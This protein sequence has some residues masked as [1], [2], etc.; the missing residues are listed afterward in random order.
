MSGQRSD[1]LARLRELAEE[2]RKPWHP[3][4]D[5]SLPER[6]TSEQWA[7]DVEGYLGGEWGEFCRE[8]NPWAVL[9]LL[10]RI[11]AVEALL[12]QVD[13][14]AHL[15]RHLARLSTREVREALRTPP[16]APS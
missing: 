9:A 4:G 14:V 13:R 2:A 1:E 10:D 11:A 5:A 15:N 3:W 16:G 6:S 12:D 8:A 7:D